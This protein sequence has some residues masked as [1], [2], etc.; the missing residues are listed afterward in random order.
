MNEKIFP[1]KHYTRSFIPEFLRHFYGLSTYR[2]K[3]TIYA[4]YFYRM[5]SRAENVWLLYDARVQGELT[6]L[7]DQTL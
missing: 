7:I 2:R 3:D 6:R 1:S 5:I 4:Y